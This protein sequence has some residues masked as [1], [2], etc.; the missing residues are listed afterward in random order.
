MNV[1]INLSSNELT[2]PVPPILEQQNRTVILDN[3][4]ELCGSLLSNPCPVPSADSPPPPLS[5]Q[6]NTAQG[7]KEPILSRQAVV[8]IVVGGSVGIV[9][10]VLVFGY[11]CMMKLSQC[12]TSLKS[13]P[14]SD[15]VHVFG[16]IS[17]TS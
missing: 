1:G 2:G 16:V 13:T 5:P 6:S 12:V 14:D 3:N 4:P 9:V 7:S 8:A 11:C 10:V 17:P 15:R